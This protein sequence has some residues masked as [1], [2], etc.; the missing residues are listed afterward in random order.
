MLMTTTTMTE[1]RLR[2]GVMAIASWAEFEA[3]H[4]DNNVDDDGRCKFYEGYVPLIVLKLPLKL[5][6]RSGM[7]LRTDVGGKRKPLPNV[8]IAHKSGRKAGRSM[9]EMCTTHLPDHHTK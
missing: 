8:Y 6:D 7:L 9:N 3:S 1:I 4:D 2:R 5:K